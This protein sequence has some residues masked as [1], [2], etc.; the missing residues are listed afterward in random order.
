M[1]KL[2]KRKTQQKKDETKHVKWLLDKGKQ[3]W[4]ERTLFKHL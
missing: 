1:P 3:N 2:Y 4:N